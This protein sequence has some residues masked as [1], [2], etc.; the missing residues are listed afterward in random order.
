MGLTQI[1]E[2]A[3]G[4]AATMNADIAFLRYGT[5]YIQGL[6]LNWI[7]SSQF[8]VS[9]GQ[10][11]DSADL[12]DM[13]LASYATVT[14]TNSGIN[15]LD[16]LTGTGTVSIT[17]GLAA[18]TGVGT[19]FLTNFGTRTIS[20]TFSSVGTAVTG[21]S[22]KFL[23]EVAIGDLLGDGSAHGFSLVTAIASDTA[24]TLSV[25]LPGGN[26]TAA[27][28][29]VIENP[30]IQFSSAPAETLRVKSITSNTA[31]TTNTNAANTHTTSAFVI[32]A[33]LNLTSGFFLFPFLASGT[34][35]TQPLASTQR[36]TLLN[37]P[38]GYATSA[39]R[40]GSLLYISAA[41]VQFTQ[42]AIGNLRE[43]AL[44]P[45]SGTPF[46]LLNGGSATTVTILSAAPVAPPT[47]RA[48]KVSL[49]L[50][51]PTGAGSTSLFVGPNASYSG[52]N[53]AQFI[54]SL[55][56]GVVGAPTDVLCDGAQQMVYFNSQASGAVSV[57]DLFGYTEGV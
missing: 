50:A 22:S 10:C 54:A 45:T 18:V 36:T 7:S 8:S 53:F 13:A 33:T 24:L 28:G 21:T 16:T 14:V 37:P 57:I 5:S 35:G 27:T 40:I 44:F 42:M 29:I 32:G 26:A 41:I 12:N 47:A 31:L 48:L 46:T 20:G 51:A 52:V 56:A 49:A 19:S 15:G 43:Y 4:W 25:A 38:T 17:T 11:R 30:T 23:T 2:G 6:R 34:S 3:V 9:P 1:Q 55:K 39:R